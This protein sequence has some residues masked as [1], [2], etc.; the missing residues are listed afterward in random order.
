MF[1]NTYNNKHSQFKTYYISLRSDA[2]QLISFNC[3]SSEPAFPRSHPRTRRIAL[4]PIT[5][6]AKFNRGLL[7]GR[8]MSRFPVFTSR[9]AR[10]R[11][12]FRK[13]PNEFTDRYGKCVAALG[14]ISASPVLRGRDRFLPGATPVQEVGRRRIF[15]EFSVDEIFSSR[16]GAAVRAALQIKACSRLS[17]AASFRYAIYLWC[18]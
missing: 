16:C 8:V 6:R 17:T 9:P 15:Y 11:H 1:Y 18:W 5:S 14:S 7:A 13:T 12:F 4:P 3:Y 10:H 2:R